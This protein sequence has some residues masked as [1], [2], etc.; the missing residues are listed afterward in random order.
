[1]F[2][3]RTDHLDYNKVEVFETSPVRLL[4][5]TFKTEQLVMSILSETCVLVFAYR[6]STFCG[7]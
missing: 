7:L 1:M 2:Y 3:D 4:T 5:K 6:Y